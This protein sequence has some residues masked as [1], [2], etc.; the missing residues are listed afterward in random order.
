[1]STRATRRAPGNC[2][3]FAFTLAELLVVIAFIVLLASLLR[4]CTRR[5]TYSLGRAVACASNMKAM[6]LA[7]QCY[8]EDWSGHAVIP[9]Q[10]Q[11]GPDEPA[12]LWHLQWPF[13][14]AYYAAGDSIGP[15]TAV[16]SAGGW[17]NPKT[18]QNDIPSGLWSH[19]MWGEDRSPAMHCWSLQ[20]R[21]IGNLD[22]SADPSMKEWDCYTNYSMAFIN[23]RWS[24][25]ERASMWYRVK[26]KEFIHPG[27]SICLMDMSA[28]SQAD[29]TSLGL[30]STFGC[31]RTNPHLE[32]SN[33]LFLDGHVERLSSAWQPGEDPLEKG[34]ITEE[35]FRAIE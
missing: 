28:T 13:V 35:M 19:P 3:V 34:D 4:T 2:G 21:E 33:F 10:K 20:R 9:W 23:A 1:M 26:S 25:G 18:G 15:K 24:L 27:E 30:W 5:E 16:R 14:M 32:E 22:N 12:N 7:F 17:Y 31:W 6:G 11:V 29:P 8:Q